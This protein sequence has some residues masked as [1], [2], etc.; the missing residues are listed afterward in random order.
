MFFQAKAFE[1]PEYTVTLSEADAQLWESYLAFHQQQPAGSFL[2]VLPVGDVTT[3]DELLDQ[4]LE[5][6]R[7]LIRQWW[8]MQP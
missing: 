4:V 6:A 3:M 8:A 1:M 7:L 2:R 5:P